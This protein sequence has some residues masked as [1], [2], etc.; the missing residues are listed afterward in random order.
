MDW[1]VSN[2]AHNVD[3]KGR[4]SIPAAFRQVIAKR[5][6]ADLIGM[7]NFDRPALDVGGQELMNRFESAMAKLDPFSPEHQDMMMLA[8]GDGTFLKTDTEGRIMMSDFI[9]EHTG[10][11]DKVTFVGMRDTFQLWEPDT[12]EDY[13]AEMRRRMIA[14]RSGQTKSAGS[15]EQ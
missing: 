4:V 8:Y 7:R 3:A 12:F 14:M 10:I 5:G 6:I 11:T 2:F 9:R 15:S 13:R 1:F